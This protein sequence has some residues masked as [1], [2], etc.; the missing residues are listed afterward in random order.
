MGRFRVMKRLC[1]W[2][3]R[4]DPTFHWCSEECCRKW[5]EENR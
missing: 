5:T 1:A 3:N 4:T 2:Y